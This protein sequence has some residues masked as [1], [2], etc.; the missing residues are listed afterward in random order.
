V[1]FH[2]WL[3]AATV[4][5]SILG[6]RNFFCQIAIR[7]LFLPYGTVEQFLAILLKIGSSGFS[8]E[9]KL[10]LKISLLHRFFEVLNFFRSFV[11]LIKTEIIE[12]PF[13]SPTI[14]V[15]LVG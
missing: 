1:D 13:S 8:L 2:H 10:S 15:I 4:P 12:I 5:K 6:Q 7:K 3:D 14:L 11:L 9:S